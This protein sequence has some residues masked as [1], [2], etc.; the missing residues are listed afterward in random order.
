[1]E[2]NTKRYEVIPDQDGNQILTIP[3]PLFGSSDV[4]VD[5]PIINIEDPKTN[6]SGIDFG[7]RLVFKQGSL[8]QEY[9]VPTRV[10][11]DELFV[12]PLGLTLTQPAPFSN[13]QEKLQY[14]VLSMT[15]VY[16]KM[17]ENLDWLKGLIQEIA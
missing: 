14:L 7:V 15:E 1:M 6:G 12:M 11:Y 13:D 2:I 3:A 10:T 17:L 8:D 4:Q 5:N 16:E 9:I